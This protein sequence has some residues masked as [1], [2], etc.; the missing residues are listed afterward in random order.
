M[1]VTISVICYKSKESGYFV[2]IKSFGRL[3][4]I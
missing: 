2:H 4:Y 1:D 3:E